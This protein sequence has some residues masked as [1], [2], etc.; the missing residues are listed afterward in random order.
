MKNN[1]SEEAAPMRV[2]H[3]AN[4]LADQQAETCFSNNITQNSDMHEN[5]A[6]VR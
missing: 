4:Q 5:A 1:L 2:S 6:H 3:S